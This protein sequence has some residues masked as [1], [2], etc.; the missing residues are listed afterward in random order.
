MNDKAMEGKQNFFRRIYSGGFELFD[1]FWAGFVLVGGVISL[2][3]SK[4]ETVESIIIGDCLKSGYFILI[5]VAVWKSASVYQG[6]KVWKILAKLTAVLTVIGSI[7]TLGLWAI[8]LSP[9]YTP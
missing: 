5:S 9:N 8:Y 6:K 7:F 4:L 2:S 1:V 3:A